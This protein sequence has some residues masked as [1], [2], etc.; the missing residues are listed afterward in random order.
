MA[1]P[2][3]IEV[4]HSAHELWHWFINLPWVRYITRRPVSKAPSHEE[5]GSPETEFVDWQQ[6]EKK[7]TVDSQSSFVAEAPRLGKTP[8]PIDHL[9]GVT[10]YSLSWQLYLFFLPLLSILRTSRHPVISP[11]ALARSSW[12]GFPVPPP[13]P[14]IIYQLKYYISHTVFTD[15]IDTLLDGPHTPSV[16]NLIA[17]KTDHWGQEASEKISMELCGITKISPHRCN[18]VTVFMYFVPIWILSMM[19]ALGGDDI[20]FS[21]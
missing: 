11:C 19:L 17:P 3:L 9:N 1:V 4:S 15:D 2:P 16:V 12:N 10:E 8:Q 6:N 7:E 21:F 14:L 5:T 18:P 13:H 20:C